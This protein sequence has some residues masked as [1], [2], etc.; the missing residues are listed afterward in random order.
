[1]KDVHIVGLGEYGHSAIAGPIVVCA[2]SVPLGTWHIFNKWGFNL[3]KR[4]VDQKNGA[5]PRTRPYRLFFSKEKIQLLSNK[6]NVADKGL[7]TWSITYCDT[8]DIEKSTLTSIKNRI[9]RSA[10]YRLCYT[11]KWDVLHDI[12]LVLGGTVN[13]VSLPSTVMQQKVYSAHTR[14]VPVHVASVLAQ[15][16]HAKIMQDLHARYPNY[17]FNRNS[18]YSSKRHIKAILRYGPIIGVHRLVPTV[19]AVNKY[20]ARSRRKV[21]VPLWLKRLREELQLE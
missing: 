5:P 2:A 10:I 16:Y 13:L 21:H 8:Y 1:M 4:F 19:R 14:I 7:I 11:N 15:N 12:E 6:L 18:G 3:N 9:A 20:I 17:E